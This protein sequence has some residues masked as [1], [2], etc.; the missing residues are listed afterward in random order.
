VEFFGPPHSL[1]PLSPPSG[2]RF[3]R[4]RQD[5]GERGVFMAIRSLGRRSLRSLTPGYNP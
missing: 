1:S 3:D 2:A 5:C 4:S